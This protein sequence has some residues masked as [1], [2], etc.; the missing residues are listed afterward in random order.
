MYLIVWLVSRLAKTLRPT[1]KR[2]LKQTTCGKSKA[3]ITEWDFKCIHNCFPQT[4]VEI[5]KQHPF[6]CTYLYPI[7]FTSASWITAC[8][9]VTTIAILPYLKWSLENGWC[10]DCNPQLVLCRAL[11]VSLKCQL[12]S[13]SQTAVG[14]DESFQNKAPLPKKTNTNQDP[15]PDTHPSNHHTAGTI[16]VGAGW[17]SM[18]SIKCSGNSTLFWE[19][20]VWSHSLSNFLFECWFNT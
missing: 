20:T 10:A 9:G 3:E 4:I 15:H 6:V 2:R 19:Y 8:L 11:Q 1:D 13:S 5:N 12:K 16:L 14:W 18:R 17:E 7:C